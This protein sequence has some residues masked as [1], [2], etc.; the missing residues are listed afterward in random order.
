M[1]IR[2]LFL[3]KE[4]DERDDKIIK[5]ILNIDIDFKISEDGSLSRKSIDNLKNKQLLESYKQAYK[6]IKKET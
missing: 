4:N 3:K 6:L 1:N 5:E 2:K